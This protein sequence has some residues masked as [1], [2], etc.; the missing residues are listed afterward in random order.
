[1]KKDSQT[2]FPSVFSKD[3]NE[4]GSSFIQTIPEAVEEQDSIFDVKDQD[5][6]D[7]KDEPSQIK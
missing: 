5:K 3:I 2:S 7:V 1:M 4:R 6:Y